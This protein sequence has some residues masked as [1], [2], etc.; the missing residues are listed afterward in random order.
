MVKSFNSYH[1]EERSFVSYIKR[2][3]HQGNLKRNFTEKQ[4]GEIDIIVSEMT[5]NL[6]KYAGSGDVLYRVYNLDEKDSVFEILCLDKGEGMAD[7][8]KMKKDGFST[9]STLGQGL[10]AIERLSNF[11][12][13]YS[14]P[15]WGTIIYAMVSTQKSTELV[16]A[17]RDI[18]VRGLL[19]NKP[20]EVVCGDGYYVH[21]TKTHCR[22]M[23][24]DGLGHGP[25]AKEAMD[26]A[27]DCFAKSTHNDPVDLLREIH[28]VVRKT[29]GLVATIAVWDKIRVEWRIC[30]VGNISTRVY[31]G[32]QYKNYMPYNGTLGLNIPH[33]MNSTVHAAEKN[34]H[35][36]MCSDGIQSRWDL[37]RYPAIFRYDGIILASCLYKD[38]VRGT[39]DAS[40]LVVKVN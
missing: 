30:G 18:S 8:F 7:T 38:Y 32:I 3:I 12:Q 10:G 16:P 6:I 26:K 22:V 21:E 15:G 36:V 24:G 25:Q 4:I 35:L 11:T 33:S 37:N 31:N 19:I 39:D 27:I 20:R 40:V 13:L 2:E 1:I 23:L 34:Q 17:G 29:R 5:S 9:S 28:E 14:I